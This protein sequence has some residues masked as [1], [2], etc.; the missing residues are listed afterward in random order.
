[1]AVNIVAAI[2][3]LTEA[4]KENTEVEKELPAVTSDDAGKCLMVDAEGKWVLGSP[5]PA[6]TKADDEGKVL[7]VNSSGVWAAASLPE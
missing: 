7:T 2:D 1:M 6:V 5:L 3:A 4:I